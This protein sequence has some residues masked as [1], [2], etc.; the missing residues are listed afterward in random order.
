ML[1]CSRCNHQLITGKYLKV[2]GLNV[3]FE[4]LSERDGEKGFGG[5]EESGSGWLDYP[6]VS[7]RSG[8]TIIVNK[9]VWLTI[10]YVM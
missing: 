1:K 6:L 8:K 7:R 5:Q 2:D 9:L 4:C 3:C 10:G